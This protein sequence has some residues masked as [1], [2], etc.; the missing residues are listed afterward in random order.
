MHGALCLALSNRSRTRLAPTPTN[1]STNSDPE[2]LK[3]GTPAPHVEHQTAKQHQRPDRQQQVEPRR[4]RL[5]DHVG[6]ARQ[7]VRGCPK[8][9]QH[10]QYGCPSDIETEHL[11]RTS[12]RQTATLRDANLR[13]ITS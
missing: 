7:L 5:A 10:V 11:A 13:Y 6:H 2:I 9:R 8:T 12:A 4:R 1:I 3:N